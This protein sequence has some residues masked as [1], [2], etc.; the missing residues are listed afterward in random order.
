MTSG[1]MNDVRS[2]FPSG[3]FGKKSWFAIFVLA[4]IPDN[5]LGLP[6]SH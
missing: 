5:G 3:A 1:V 2:L 4:E 6:C